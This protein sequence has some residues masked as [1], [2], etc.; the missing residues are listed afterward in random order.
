MHCHARV[1]GY[2][3]AAGKTW[4]GAESVER[5]LVDIVEYRVVLRAAHV[6]VAN[7]VRLWFSSQGFERW[8]RRDL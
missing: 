5:A 8:E 2:A 3:F 6:D 7:G 1:T 4:R